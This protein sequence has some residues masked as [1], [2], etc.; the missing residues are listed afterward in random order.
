M[1]AETIQTLGLS[2]Q[3][4]TCTL[5]ACSRPAKETGLALNE[6]E[7]RSVSA[8]F[9]AAD[10]LLWQAEAGRLPQLGAIT[11]DAPDRSARWSNSRSRQTGGAGRLSWCDSRTALL[12]SD[13]TRS[14]W[15]DQRRRRPRSRGRLSLRFDLTGGP[16][17]RHWEQWAKHAENA[18]VAAGLARGLATGLMGAFGELQDN[19]FEHSGRPASGLLAYGAATAP[20]NS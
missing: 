8:T 12:Q 20:S 13:R 4:V 15:P 18:A 2:L 19:V 11:L 7:Q 10:D 17:T 1:L 9:E 3:M 14:P 16:I 5:T 6:G